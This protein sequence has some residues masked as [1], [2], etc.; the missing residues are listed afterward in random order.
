LD[1]SVLA[2]APADNPKLATVEF[3]VFG[4]ELMPNSTVPVTLPLTALGFAPNQECHITDGWSKEVLGV[5]KNDEFQPVLEAHQSGF[6]LITPLNGQAIN[7]AI[8][9]DTPDKQ[10]DVYSIS[11]QKIRSQVRLSDVSGKL[12]AGIYIFG[13][14]K[15]CISKF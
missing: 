4:N 5:Y 7:S 9:K 8:E 10:V 3:M 12:P 6:Y 15:V 14:K 1:Y 13:N 11:G 2:D